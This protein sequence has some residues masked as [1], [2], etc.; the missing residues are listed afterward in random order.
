MHLLL[1][2]IDNGDLEVIQ[3]LCCVFSDILALCESICIYV[4]SH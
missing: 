4:V 1:L 3:T 2:R